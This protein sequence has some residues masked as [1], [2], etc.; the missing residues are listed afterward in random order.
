MDPRFDFRTLLANSQRR[1][2]IDPLSRMM[3]ANPESW[4]SP[5]IGGP[6][7]PIDFPTQRVR[8][9]YGGPLGASFSAINQGQV[10]QSF[11]DDPYGLN[12]P[13]AALAE[14]G[15]GFQGSSDDWLAGQPV[16]NLA[17]YDEFGRSPAA[18]NE[19]DI[20]EALSALR[21]GRPDALEIMGAREGFNPDAMEMAERRFNRPDTE[22]TYL[23]MADRQAMVTRNAAVKGAM[24][25]ARMGVAPSNMPLLT[26]LGMG[27]P[28]EI[29]NRLNLSFGG[30]AA[31]RQEPGRQF[32]VAAAE[33]ARRFD[34]GDENTD[35][36][37]AEVA[38][39][40]NVGTAET[41]RQFNLGRTDAAGIREEETRRW[42]VEQMA[43][44]LL[45]ER[46]AEKDAANWQMQTGAVAYMREARKILPNGSPEQ[47]AEYAEY[48]WKLDQAM[49]GGAQGQ[50]PLAGGPSPAAGG[51]MLTGQRPVWSA[52][53]GGGGWPKPPG[54]SQPG[55]VTTEDQQRWNKINPLTLGNPE[56]DDVG[57]FLSIIEEMGPGEM[58]HPQLRQYMLKRF[59]PDKLNAYFEQNTFFPSEEGARRNRWATRLKAR[60]QSRSMMGMLFPPFLASQFGY[61]PST[62]L[63]ADPFQGPG[64]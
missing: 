45:A 38:R 53:G 4:Y 43:K 17:D 61:S 3:A 7:T 24:R 11:I 5:A 28:D 32:D 64:F 40:F 48:L 36:A 10:P 62:S 2:G 31:L 14:A 52:P 16:A 56:T 50:Q 25:K 63:I 51:E 15:G 27:L 30:A 21:R 49:R 13:A 60:P 59:P 47:V 39:Q 46:Q 6:G 8:G 19:S 1:R 54:S 57:H 23:P 22:P 34:V 29:G 42:K 26:M 41:E 35:E 18:R 58:D 12:D 37:A 9:T 55:E 20:Q 33:G 44:D